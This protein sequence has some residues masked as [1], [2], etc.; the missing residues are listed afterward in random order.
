MAADRRGKLCSGCIFSIDT[1]GSKYTD[2]FDFNG[3]NG[4]TPQ[5]GSLI[6][7]RNILSGMTEFGGV[8]NDGCIF[9][10]DTNGSGYKKLLD[11]TTTLI[12]RKVDIPEAH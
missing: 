9:S 1:N 8:N 10:V 3:T 7:S 5:G 4:A 6:L 11:F 2:I 12:I